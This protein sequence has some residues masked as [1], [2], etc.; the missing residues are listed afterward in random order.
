MPELRFRQRLLEELATRRRRNPR[1][2]LRAVATFLGTDHSTLSQILRGA[3]KAPVGPVRRWGKK[4]GMSAEEISVYVAAEHVPDAATAQWQD[5]LRHRCSSVLRTP[6][7]AATASRCCWNAWG[8]A[9][10]MAVQPCLAARAALVGPRPWMI[11]YG[12]QCR[13][14]DC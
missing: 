9:A 2:S 7:L 1:Y 8:F 4:L 12:F 13:R 11:L 10:S 3:R 5:H 6:A 14:A